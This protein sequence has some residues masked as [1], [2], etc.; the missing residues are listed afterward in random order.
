MVYPGLCRP[1]NLKINTL[2]AGDL[3]QAWRIALPEDCVIEFEDLAMG[4]QHQDLNE[5]VGDFILRRSDGLFAYQLAVVVDDA[6]QGISHVVRGADLLNNTA[7]QIYLQKILELPTPQYRH[8]PLVLDEHGEKLSKQ[9]QADA[10]DTRDDSHVL[11]ELRKAAI[12]LGLSGLPE[13][14]KVTVADWL[15]SATQAWQ[16]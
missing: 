16:S 2:E 6:L 12:H 5:E 8:L 3:K 15:A 4:K 1:K 14:S 11:T 9:T 10:I 13:G 7:R